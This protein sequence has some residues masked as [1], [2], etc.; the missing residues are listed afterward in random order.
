[1]ELHYES[2]WLD[3]PSPPLKPQR[4]P[5]K[6]AKLE[7]KNAKD[8]VKICQVE[9]RSSLQVCRGAWP[10]REDKGLQQLGVQ[11]K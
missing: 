5:P 9:K 8:V 11:G 7:F 4:N 3:W 1:M 6:K 2:Q 10:L